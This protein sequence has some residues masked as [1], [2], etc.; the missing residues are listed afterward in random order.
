M[1]SNK[2]IHT[3]Y[4]KLK[5]KALQKPSTINPPTKPLAKYMISAF[6]TNKNKPRVKMVMG[7]VKNIRIGLIN[8]LSKLITIETI[9]A[10][11]KFLT[12]IP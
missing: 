10:V 9:S 7:K 4:T 1:Y 8:A 2:D 11:P 6:I 5:N 3:E 12:E